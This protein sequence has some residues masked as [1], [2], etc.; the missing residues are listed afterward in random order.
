MTGPAPAHPVFHRAAD[1]AEIL[2]CS[3]WWVKEQ[4]R[5]RRIPFCWIGGSYRFTDEHLAQI[6]RL[7]EVLPTDP[8]ASAPAPRRPATGPTDTE[9]APVVRLVA[10]QPRRAR[11]AAQAAA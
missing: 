9:A 10:R 5:Q 7:F 6:A 8:T 1:V 2:H 11:A 3:P 4:A